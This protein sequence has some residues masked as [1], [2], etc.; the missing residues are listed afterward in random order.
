MTGS[1]ASVVFR[2]QRREEI[3]ESA[4]LQ[5]YGLP[6]SWVEFYIQQAP[7]FT[8]VKRFRDDIV[9]SRLAV[10]ED[11]LSTIFII[12]EGFAVKPSYEPF[13]LFNAWK[14]ETFIRGLAPIKPIVALVIRETLGAM[15]QFAD[16]LLKAFTLPEEM[17]P[18]YFVFMSGYNIKK[19]NELG[20]YLD[21]DVW[22]S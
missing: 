1:F 6:I 10:E 2:D 19:L 4:E 15:D 8:K 12:D 14:E 3:K 13:S 16:M 7:F 11:S 9:H 22:Y 20:D 21:S 5:E 17:S 18:G